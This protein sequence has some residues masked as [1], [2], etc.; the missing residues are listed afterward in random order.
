LGGHGVKA[1]FS[2]GHAGKA[3]AV[4]IKG[5]GAF[6]HGKF[7]GSVDQVKDHDSFF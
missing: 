1:F 3:R 5:M 2:F 4:D 6:F 7:E